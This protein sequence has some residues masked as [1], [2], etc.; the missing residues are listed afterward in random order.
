MDILLPRDILKEIIM[1]RPGGYY[2]L[3]QCNKYFRNLCTELK[4]RAE[5]TFPRKHV[6]S[7]TFKN[8]RSVIFLPTYYY[9]MRGFMIA[10]PVYHF[11][12]MVV[13]FTTINGLKEGKIEGF[14]NNKLVMLSEYKNNVPC[15]NYKVWYPEQPTQ[16]WFET[17]LVDGN[18]RGEI[19]MYK[20]N[21]GILSKGM[22]GETKMVQPHSMDR[23][24]LACYVS[25]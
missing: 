22:F 4:D 14:E 1:V 16:L 12:L 7:I 5:K 8:W 9:D 6:Q 13:K 20:K 18:L 19:K 2:V 24:M 25:K 10:L 23:M 21:G 17:F 3:S 15:G 11:P